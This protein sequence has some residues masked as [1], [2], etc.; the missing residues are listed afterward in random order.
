MSLRA[1]AEQLAASLPP[2]A[3]RRATARLSWR[4]GSH[5]RRR[6]GDG[7]EFWQYRLAEPGDSASRID[8]RQSARS[9]ALFVR[10]REM[11]NPETLWLWI[12]PQPGMDWPSQRPKRRRAALLALGLAIAAANQDELVAH[13]G[14]VAPGSGMAQLDLLTRTLAVPAAVPTHAA[15]G[16]VVL[17]GDWLRAEGVE[18][19]RTLL[20]RAPGATG[21]VVQVLDRTERDFPFAGR[22]RFQAPAGGPVHETLDA[23]GLRAA[24]QQRLQERQAALAALCQAQ[25]FGFAVHVTDEAPT[26]AAARLWQG[27]CEQGRAA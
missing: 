13:W 19:C 3:L 2:L 20:A 8:W 5:G 25:G 7:N 24:Y 18:E 27:I 22:L 26:A 14:A 6:T 15:T 16:V 10:E 11:A 17:L 9:D 21:M 4:A 12:D 23:A 1:E